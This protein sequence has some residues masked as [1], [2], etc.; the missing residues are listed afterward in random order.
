MICL[1]STFKWSKNLNNLV[2]CSRSRW[3]NHRQQ[4]TKITSRDNHLARGIETTKTRIN[5]VEKT[6]HVEIIS[7]LLL[8]V[9]SLGKT[10]LSNQVTWMEVIY[11]IVRCLITIM[12]LR[13]I[14]QATT[15]SMILN[16]KRR[17]CKSNRT[18]KMMIAS[19]TTI[20][21]V[22]MICNYHRVSK[23]MQVIE[24]VLRI[25]KRP[26]RGRK[27]DSTTL[28]NLIIAIYT[29]PTQAILHLWDN[30]KLFPLA[31]GLLLQMERTWKMRTRT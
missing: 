3:V 1:I 31:T 20:V 9:W 4:M 22:E 10:V 24:R 30:L 17:S 25:L 5:S 7:S 21:I 13:W 28:M 19:L 27:K 15:Q 2:I 18:Y 16:L 8:K 26:Y 6:C 11:K 14:I 23:W 12:T 29:G